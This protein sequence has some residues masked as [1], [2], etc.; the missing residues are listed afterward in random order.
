L[1]PN[2]AVEISVVVLALQLLVATGLSD[3]QSTSRDAIYGL[4]SP[5]FIFLSESFL[6]MF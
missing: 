5:Q 3:D 6:S 4:Y 2:D 1:V